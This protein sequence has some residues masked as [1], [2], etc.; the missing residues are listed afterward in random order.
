MK[1]KNSSALTIANRQ[2]A[3]HFDWSEGTLRS[4]GFENRL[5]GRQHALTGTRELALVFSAAVDRVAEPLA[6]VED[7][8][9]RRA[10]LTRADRAEFELESPSRKL[11]VTLRVQLE[12]PTRRKWVEV[13]NTSKEECLLLDV[14][15]D[16]F[17]TDA[18]VTGGGHG[19]PVFIADEIFATIEHPTGDNKVTAQRVQMAH[20]P[21]KRLPPRGRAGQRCRAGA[22]QRALR[23]LCAGPHQAAAED[24]GHL[25]A[26]WHQQPVGRAPDAE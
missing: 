5:S 3:W 10:R 11:G 23:R 21:G 19:K 1:V 2:L 13:T 18:A 4:T 8:V 24:D 6:R 12:G 26:V 15:L 9:V 22:D 25:H 17:T 16:D 14:E 20:Y 7:F